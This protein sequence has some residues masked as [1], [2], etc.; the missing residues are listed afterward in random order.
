MN[1]LNVKQKVY[2]AVL[3]AQEEAAELARQAMTEADQA[4]Q[5]EVNTMDIYESYRSQ[6]LQKSEMFA[7]QFQKASEQLEIIRRIDPNRK[8]EAVEF[9]A[10]VIT[11][12]QKM[13]IAIG[14]GKIE[15]DGETWYVISPQ[16][17]IFAAMK[18]KREGDEFS[19]NNVKHKI[20]QIL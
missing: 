7:R 11:S 16:V 5:E 14:M 12:K 3:R 10:A 9:G 18:G 20:M 4:A 1:A 15:I 2:E 8:C 19:F 6:Y 13:F 17:P